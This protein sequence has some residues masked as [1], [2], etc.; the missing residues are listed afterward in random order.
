[1]KKNI[2]KKKKFTISLPHCEFTEVKVTLQ[3]EQIWDDGDRPA[4]VSFPSDGSNI[5]LFMMESDL[6]VL[7]HALLAKTNPGLDDAAV[8]MDI[9]ID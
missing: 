2:M 8:A 4:T 1:M 6:R 7:A 3:A 5:K 9:L